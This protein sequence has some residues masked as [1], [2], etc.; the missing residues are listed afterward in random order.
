MQAGYS[1]KIQNQIHSNALLNNI[2]L[3]KKPK[4]T[5]M[6]GPFR[7]NSIALM[8]PLRKP[9]PVWEPTKSLTL[10]GYGVGPM[11]RVLFSDLKV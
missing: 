4:R 1:N 9:C 5:K 11:L 6:N 7:N 8:P 3:S 2:I 10:G